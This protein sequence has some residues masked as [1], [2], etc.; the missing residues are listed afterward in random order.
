[1]YVHTCVC[2]YIYTSILLCCWH[3]IG[4]SF[5]Y[6]KKQLSKQLCRQDGGESGFHSCLPRA[7]LGFD[8]MNTLVCYITQIH[9]LKIIGKFISWQQERQRAV[10]KKITGSDK[11]I[12][13]LSFYFV[14]WWYISG[15]PFSFWL[16]A[17]LCL[18]RT[19][20]NSHCK[21]LWWNENKKICS[22]NLT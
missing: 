4:V 16:S 12:K 7:L 6:L 14:Y 13:T 17:L 11:N 9:L 21:S 2:I 19:N 1:M 18:L 15:L 10:E 20:D 5:S 8:R 3:Y 22:F